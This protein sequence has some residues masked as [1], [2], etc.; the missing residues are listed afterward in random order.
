MLFRSLYTSGTTASPKGVM[1]THKNF[2]SNFD[3]VSKVRIVNS[4]DNVVSL[5]PLHHSYPFMVTIILPLLI[6]AKITFLNSLKSE[7]L[8]KCLRETKGAI[9]VGVP[10]LYHLLHKSI[11]EKISKPETL[12]SLLKI[13]N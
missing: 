4:K 9:L 10:Q 3:S 2:C 13:F 5:L 7:D 8:L 11:L 12:L 6:G 1:L